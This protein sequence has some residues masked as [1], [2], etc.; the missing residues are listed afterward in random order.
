VI[1]AVTGTFTV[2][3][4]EVV[5]DGIAA[6]GTFRGQITDAAGNVLESG[7]QQIALP[8]AN[9]QQALVD[10]TCEI[11]RLEL[12]PLHLDLLGLVVDLDPVV[13]VITA[14][15]GPGNLLGNLL[16]AI[17]GLLDPGGLLEDILGELVDLLN[18]L[19]GLLD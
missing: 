8:V 15:S 5:G 3:R 11:L 19:I 14:E 16:C 6:V 4:F 2:Q 7:R 10:A 18:Q 17:A 1:D 12:G 13:L 9:L